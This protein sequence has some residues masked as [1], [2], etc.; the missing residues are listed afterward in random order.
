MK[1]VNLLI[2]YGWLN[3]FNSAINQWNNEK[4]SQEMA[5]YDLLVFGNGLQDPSHADFANTQ[6]I[7]SRIKVLN[8]SS[9]IFGYVATTEVLAT[10]QTKTGQWNTL[11]IHGI[12]MDVAGY[13]YGTKRADFNTRVNYVHG[14]SSAK[15]CFVNAW[16]E[17][18]I[19]GIA[20]DP[21]YPNSTYNPSLVASKLNNNDWYLLESFAVNTQAYSGNNGY[22]DKATWSI[23]GDKAMS[24]RGTFGLKTAAVGIIGDS[25]PSAQALADFAY[26]S[27]MAYELDGHGTSNTDYGAGDANTRWWVRPLPRGIL[28]SSTS[29]V[30]T[31]DANNTNVCLRYTNNMKIFVDHTI[32]AQTSSVFQW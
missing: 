10:F 8:P 11:G 4:V 16:N 27:S 23:R 3:P 7:I 28:Q 2:Y 19:V 14:R 6:A 15:L 25:D 22:C 18:H 13:D 26:R 5:K 29:V 17:D 21:N 30:V 12:F 24:L 32:G 20:N 9:L 31:P 1:P